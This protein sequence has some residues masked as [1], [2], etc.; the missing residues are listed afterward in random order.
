[1]AWKCPVSPTFG[2]P[3]LWHPHYWTV[4]I[5]GEPEEKAW[6]QKDALKKGRLRFRER[7]CTQNVLVR[8]MYIY[9]FLCPVRMIGVDPYVVRYGV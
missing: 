4:Q 3:R 6:D 5:E 1:M 2:G 8:P 9:E 7:G